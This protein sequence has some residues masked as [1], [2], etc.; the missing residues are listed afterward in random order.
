[1]I[2]NI[3][4]ISLYSFVSFFT[5][6]F[7][8]LIVPIIAHNLTVEEYGY[9]TLIISVIGLSQSVF[10][11]GFEHSLNYYF[12]KFKSTHNRNILISTQ[13]FFII[14]VA[15]FIILSIAIF[16]NNRI[17]FINLILIW[18]LLSV[19]L[20]YFS[21]LLKVDMQVVAFTK[22]QVLKSTILLFTIYLFV[23]I[24]DLKIEGVLYSNILAI[25]IALVYMYIFLKKYIILSFNINLLKKILYY[26]LPLMP[27]GPILWAST[28]LDRYYILYY[29]NEHTLG[30]YGFALSI[31]LIPVFLK[32]AFKS[33]LDP[34]IMKTYHQDTV[35]T[36]NYISNFFSLSL[37]IFSFIFLL[38]SV[39]AKDIV[40]LIGGEKF[41]NS[42][43][44]IPWILFI[45]LITTF[46]Q[47]F[48]YGI[49]FNKKNKLVLQG[50]ILMLI[51]NIILAYILI[52]ILGVYG[53]IISN[54]IANIIYTF[55][56]YSKSNTFYKIKYFFKTNLLILLSSL[57]FS[58]LS[59][60]YFNDSYSVKFLMIIIFIL[61][62][63]NIYKIGKG[64]I[65]ER[66]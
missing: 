52:H 4:N 26:G 55:Y 16:L 9:Y 42:I 49:N 1:M 2:N 60:I 43:Q 7:S 18:S 17:E 53:V 5:K 14:F 63:S 10:L 54:L 8:L 48:V 40:L 64:F 21:S 45:V 12:N 29:L 30:I 24:Y 44:Y 22:S 27:A 25:F 33:A 3:K 57:L 47:Y 6:S 20:S 11:F 62:N 41:L 51:I 13:L 35:K 59:I 32:M 38:L 23:T 19:L 61:I 50:L 65:N 39:Y 37:F 34:L 36:K 66:N 31:G 28:Q 15:L 58:L 46:N 56:L